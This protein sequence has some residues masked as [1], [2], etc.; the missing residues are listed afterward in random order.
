M[1]HWTLNTYN[2]LK[3]NRCNTWS[4]WHPLL[5]YWRVNCQ[6]PI[7]DVII[8][9]DWWKHHSHKIAFTPLWRRRRQT[10]KKD[11]ETICIL[12]FV[13]DCS[14]KS[15]SIQMHIIDV[16]IV[17]FFFI[18]YFDFVIIIFFSLFFLLLQVKHLKMTSN[19]WQS[20]Y[21]FQMKMRSKKF[22]CFSFCS[23]ADSCISQFPHHLHHYWKI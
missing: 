15:Q 7:F 21:N 3:I 8:L 1:M 16:H 9:D 22:V 5:S 11:A 6:S 12:R 19:K 13:A 17:V 18:R 10:R 23:R 14:Y 4:K 2:I 20:I